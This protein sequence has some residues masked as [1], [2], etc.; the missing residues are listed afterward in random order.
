M[1]API[2]PMTVRRFDNGHGSLVEPPLDADWP[3][4]RQGAWHVAVLREDTGLD[5]NLYW[6]A[7]NG[8]RDFGVSIPGVSSSGPYTLD[9]LAVYLHGIRTGMCAAQ[10]REVYL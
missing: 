3:L 8:N 10:G 4:V 1:T 5:V 2:P 7:A 9:Q 6:G